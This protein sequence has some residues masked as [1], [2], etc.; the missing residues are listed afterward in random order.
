[1]L[2][3]L[4]IDKTSERKVQTALRRQQGD[5]GYIYYT[6]I[7]ALVRII[8]SILWRKGNHDNTHYQKYCLHKCSIRKIYGIFIVHVTKK[9]KLIEQQNVHSV[10]EEIKLK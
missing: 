10:V 9:Y 1:M 7:T 6:D 4:K 5:L 3:T 2:H 8:L